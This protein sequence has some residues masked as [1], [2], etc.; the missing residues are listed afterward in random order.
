MPRKRV[1]EPPS[2]KTWEDANDALRQI[3]EAQLALLDIEGEMNKQILGAKKA[4]EE[5]GKQF[6]DRVS[7]LERELKDFVTEH[8]ADMGKT[9]TKA[10]TFGEVGF[11]LS[12]SVSLPRAKEK[13]EEI[14]RR[15]KARAMTDCIIVKE[16]VSKEA[17]KKYGEDTVNAV[18]GTWKQ[19]DVFGY[20]LNLAR[21]EQIKA[22]Q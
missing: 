1:V 10:L 7:K 6:K 8:R 5:Q 13:L 20:E 14:I 9:K 4:A 22:G 12:T 2:I 21:L 11:R 15:L 3:A 16:D 19:S 18:G 17:L